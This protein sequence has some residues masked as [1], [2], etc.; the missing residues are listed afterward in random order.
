ML[1][2]ASEARL[3]ALAQAGRLDAYNQLVLRYQQLVYNIAFYALGDA[4]LASDVTQE[5]F[6]QGFRRLRAHRDAGFRDVGFRDVIVPLVVACCRA[7]WGRCKRL[8]VDPTESRQAQLLACL[9]MLTEEERVTL[10][11]ADIA[12]CSY[13]EVAAATGLPCH[14]LAACL[15]RARYRIAALNDRLCPVK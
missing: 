8:R 15:A 3:V 12:G 13:A 14:A 7:Q 11:L 10:I 4:G 5:T 2:N 9:R 6:A 1:R